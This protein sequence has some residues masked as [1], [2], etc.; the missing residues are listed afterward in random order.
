MASRSSWPSAAC[1]LE[2]GSSSA[3]RSVVRLEPL[4]H[5]ERDTTP[6]LSTRIYLAQRCARLNQHQSLTEIPGFPKLSPQRPFSG[7]PSRQDP[8]AKAALASENHES[9]LC[10]ALETGCLPASRRSSPVA[11]RRL[12]RRCGWA[13]SWA[14]GPTPSTWLALSTIA[15]RRCRQ[16]TTDWLGP[17]TDWR[18]VLR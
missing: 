10:A 2:P 3:A 15:A 7:S 4:S 12:S 1:C 14:I 17:R 6:N 8:R 11:G 16:M 18:N 9:P 13:C 5:T